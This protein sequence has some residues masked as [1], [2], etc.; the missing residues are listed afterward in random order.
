MNTLVQQSM[1]L[2]T[3]NYS[4]CQ[5]VMI[6]IVASFNGLCFTFSILFATVITVGCLGLQITPQS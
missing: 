5:Q 4:E 2:I 3:L 6:A 1:V